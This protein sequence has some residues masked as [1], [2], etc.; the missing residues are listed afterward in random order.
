MDLVG[1]LRICVIDS[2]GFKSATADTKALL[3]DC[4][5]KNPTWIFISAVADHNAT[6]SL[7]LLY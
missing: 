6:S 1:Q 7:L 2:A 3:V 5:R 4:S